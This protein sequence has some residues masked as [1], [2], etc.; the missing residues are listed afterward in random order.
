[1]KTIRLHGEL[2]KKFGEYH[3]FAVTS[4]AEAVRALCVNFKG[5][6]TYLLQ[7]EPG[8]HVLVDKTD[9]DDKQLLHPASAEI[10]FIPVI[11][12]A[13]PGGRGSLNIIIGAVLVIAGAAI[14]YFSGGSLAGVGGFLMKVGAAM[15]IGGVV[16]ALTPVPKAPDPPERPDNKP[17]YV[18]NGPVNTTAQGQPVPVGYGRLIVGGAVISAGITV[19]SLV[20]ITDLPTGSV[21]YQG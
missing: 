16:Q 6:Q 2:G 13:G 7:H 10:E 8:F 1:M 5:F 17:S 18:F 20:P 12:G 4:V 9:I 11:A 19:D 3:R 15:I 21:V 14:T